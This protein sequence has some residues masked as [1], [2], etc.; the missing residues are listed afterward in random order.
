MRVTIRLNQEEA[1]MLAKISSSASSGTYNHA[2]IIRLLIRREYM[3]RTQ[4]TSKVKDSDIRSDVRTERP[5][6]AA[7]TLPQE[8]L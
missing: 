6:K 5:R 1:E 2:E 4:G 8:A 7:D 3:R